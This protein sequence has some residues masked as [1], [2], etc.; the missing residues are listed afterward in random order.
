M[1]VFFFFSLELVI[2]IIELILLS[3]DLVV[4]YLGTLQEAR[5]SI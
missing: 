3:W 1:Y 4:Y 5:V 2:H